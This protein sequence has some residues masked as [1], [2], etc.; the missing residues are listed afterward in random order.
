MHLGHKQ[1]G[2]FRSSISS[3]H[4]DLGETFTFFF[5]MLG[6]PTQNLNPYVLMM[7]SAKDRNCRDVADR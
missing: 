3:G 2:S 1:A 6:V 4:V 5:L 7:Q